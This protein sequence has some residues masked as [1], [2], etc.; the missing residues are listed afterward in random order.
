MTTYYCNS[1][2]ADDTGDGSFSNPWQ[3]IASHRSTLVA[4]DT[5]Y[6]RGGS[7]TGT[8]RTYNE[9]IALTSATSN[10]GSAGSPITIAVYQNEYIK[11][12]GATGS[13][14]WGFNDRD[15]WVLQGNTADTM[16]TTPA[17]FHF[18]IDAADRGS[19]GYGVFI[20]N[21]SVNIQVRNIRIH[22]GSYNPALVRIAASSDCTIAHCVIHDQAPSAGVDRHGIYISTTAAN[23]CDDNI[24]EYCA[25]YDVTDC[26]QIQNTTAAGAIN[27]TIIRYNHLYTTLN[28][29]SE[30]AI[31]DKDGIGTLI[32]GNEMHGFR[33]CDGSL[34]GSGSDGECVV[35]QDT[36]ESAEVYDNEMYDFSGAAVRFNQTTTG[37]KVYRNVIHSLASESTIASPYV[38]YIVARTNNILAHN[39]VVGK[40]T[41]SGEGLFRFLNSTGATF[42]NN[43][44]SGTGD[45]IE[46]SGLTLTYD[47]NGWDDC[48]QTKSGTGDVLTEPLFVDE[49]NDDLRLSDSSPW[50]D[51]GDT[52]SPYSPTAIGAEVDIGYWEWE[53]AGGSEGGGGPPAIVGRTS[54]P[55]MRL[56]KRL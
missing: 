4:G 29:A 7:T 8:R 56:V 1:A 45:I 54:R 47:H 52:Y 40:H 26:I 9:N 11:W 30:N 37:P 48:D 2:A 14:L 13:A 19:S 24:I 42:R 38:F 21:G 22:N 34:G 3:L 32:Y 20:E 28:G 33:D 44:F 53:A 12:T 43:G 31:D 50:I 35:L 10:N 6:L 46:G 16:S 23:L 27:G 17:N 49:A 36:S 55:L 41:N 18:I 25:I 51:A 5:V 15:Y 39:T